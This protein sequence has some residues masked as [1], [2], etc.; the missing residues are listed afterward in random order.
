[1][2]TFVLDPSV[3]TVAGVP[4]LTKTFPKKKYRDRQ[5]KGTDADW[6]K[7]LNESTTVY[8]GN[9]SCYT[10]E[11]QIHELFSR[12][13][14]IKRI[15]MGLDKNKKTPC[16]F[17]FVE[18]DERDS[19]MKSINYINRTLLDGRVLTV[20]IDAGFE[21]GRQ[22]GRGPSGGQISDER[23]REREQ[24]GNRGG[25]QGGAAI[26]TR[27]ITIVACIAIISILMI[28]C[29]SVASIKPGDIVATPR[30]PF[31]NRYMKPYYISRLQAANETRDT[32]EKAFAHTLVTIMKTAKPTL[33]QAFMRETLADK[34]LKEKAIAIFFNNT[35][36]SNDE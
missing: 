36:N 32:F 12:C 3:H 16:G 21:E 20:D 25:Y 26:F 11:Y 14:S 23:R 10:S 13:G 9:L 17:C 30:L 33:L 15:I 6:E 18:F 2:A 22:Y 27:S 31:R 29:Q 7:K 5:F 24:G 4:R 1:M 28:S 35:D 19:T 8:V 34:D